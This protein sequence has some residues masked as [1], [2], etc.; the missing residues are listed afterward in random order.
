MALVVKNLPAN[1]GDITDSWSGRSPG[2]RHGRSL[3][4]SC[5][6]NPLD[7]GAWP[8]TIHRVAELDTTEATQHTLIADLYVVAVPSRSV[9]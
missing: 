7:R 5:L 1:A 4:Y 3:Q 9:L 2:G 6:E 8:A